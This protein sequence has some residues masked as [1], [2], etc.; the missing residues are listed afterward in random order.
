MFI[1]ATTVTHLGTVFRFPAL[2]LL[3]VVAPLV[4]WRH[5]ASS[6]GA[7]IRF[8]SLRNLKRLAPTWTLLAR[9]LL[10]V[11]RVLALALLVLALARPQAGREE[12][13]ITTLGIDIMLAVDVSG[14]MKAMDFEIEGKRQNRLE[15][16][17]RAVEQFIKNRVN[18]RIGL[19]VFARRA[20]LQCPL[21]LDYDIL[22]DFLKR[23]EIVKDRRE[24]ATAVGAAIGTCAARLHSVGE[25][26]NEDEK[27]Q[28]KVVILLTDGRNNVFEPL[29][30][31]Q[32][33][34]IAKTLGVKIYTIGAGTV[35]TAPF[36]VKDFF[37]RTT[38]IGQR[39]DIDDDAL[40]KIAEAC[41]GKYFRA[42]DTRS[43]REIYERIDKIERTKKEV[44]KYSEYDELFTYFCLPA[45]LLLLLEVGLANTVFR[46]IP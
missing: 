11:L 10:V 31:D 17:K 5:F 12:S 9:H 6:Q 4:L 33:V 27:P 21:T 32:A 34:E 29:N 41:G 30:P 35:G 19:V 18:D 42:T 1:A 22:L 2:L 14:S 23:T 24:D 20:Y 45:L 26:Q 16:A 8:S 28:G 46:R 44:T 25:G 38:Y 39:V 36:P 43:L 15:V 40:T 3:L 7:A 37:G 13:K